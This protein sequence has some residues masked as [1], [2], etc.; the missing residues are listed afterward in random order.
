MLPEGFAAEIVQHLVDISGGHCAIDDDAVVASAD[1][2]ARVEIL[3]GLL[4]LHEE[5]EYRRELSRE[6]EAALEASQ[7]RF[8]GI[9]D[10]VGTALWEEDVSGVKDALDDAPRTAAWFLERTALLESL[11][12]KVRVRAANPAALALFGVDSP[13]SLQAE[14]YG[15]L[16]PELRAGFAARLAAMSAGRALKGD[17]EVAYRHAARGTVHVLFSVRLQGDGAHALLS[18]VDLTERVNAERETQRM[19][20]E[21]DQFVYVASHD[22]R[23]PL[24]AIDNLSSWLQQDLD[25]VLDPESR[26]NLELLRMRVGRMESLLDGLLSYARAGAKK[27]EVESVDLGEVMAAVEALLLVPEGF[28]LGLEGGLRIRTARAPLQQV[29]HNLV[30]NA[31]K[32]H[33]A[34]VGRVDV[35]VTEHVR[36]LEIAVRDD[37]PGIDPRFQ[38]KIFDMFQTLRPR[39]EVEGSGLGLALVRKIVSSVGGDVRVDSAPGAGTTFTFTWPKTWPSEERDDDRTENRQRPARR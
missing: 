37:G 26:E 36:H 14:L 15:R 3:S 30:G 24:G 22:L 16:P 8:Q 28:A 25:E 18:A 32:H 2:P 9:F 6:R 35:V 31:L 33:H 13:A 5:L 11:A 21:I 38:E 23:A 27:A 29:L 7:R 17:V 39:D 34:D 19:A 20:K 12:R 10:D 4:F 1:D